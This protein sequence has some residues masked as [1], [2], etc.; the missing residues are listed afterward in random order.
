MTITTEETRNEYTATASQTVFNYTFKIFDDTDLSVYQT[1]SGA[2]A[3][4]VSDLITGYS[5]SGEGD[6]DGGAITLNTGATLGDLITIVSNIPKSRT[7]NYQNNGDFKPA[8]VNEDFDR[9]VSI[10]KQALDMASRALLLQESQQGTKP[11]SLPNPEAGSHLKW[12]ATLDGMENVVIG[13]GLELPVLQVSSYASVAAAIAAIG[14]TSVELWLDTNETLQAN[15]TFNANTTIRPIN[16][17]L[18]SDDSNNADLI[19]GGA[20]IAAPGQRLFNWG[21]G[22]GS[23]TIIKGPVWAG[24]FYDGLDIGKAVNQA[25]IANITVLIEVGS[26]PLLTTIVQVS[27]GQNL[28]GQGMDDATTIEKQADITGITWGMGEGSLRNFTLD[29]DGSDS[30]KV[31]ISYTNGARTYTDNVEVINQDSHGFDFKKGNLA[32]FG[33]IKAKSNGGNGFYCDGVDADTNAGKISF[34]EATGNTLD[35]LRL[36]GSWAQSWKIN[37]AVCQSNSRYGTYLD[38]IQCEITTY[39]EDNTTDDGV[40]GT[41]SQGV[42]AKCL[43]NGFTDNGTAK[44]NEVRQ[45]LNTKGTQG[46]IRSKIKELISTD[47]VTAG[48]WTQEVTGVGAFRIQLD[49]TSTDGTLTIDHASAPTYKTSLAVGGNMNVG[50]GK[51]IGAS[52]TSARLW[53]G[54]GSPEG[55]QAASPGSL[56]FNVSGTSAEYPQYQKLTGTG[57][58]GWTGLGTVYP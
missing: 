56:W 27:S 32:V 34:L 44:N 19:I 54:T 18:L 48:V 42:L 20:I 3:N 9:V 15:T 47:G 1:S 17:F 4:D 46:V 40:L 22:S 13:N 14:S 11:F 5:V 28:I 7:T 29:S 2:V 24:W 50:A 33:F 58:T 37:Y 57:N 53:F 55:V 39:N 16:G 6:E 12:N 21:N 31:G 43:L 49:G 51:Y 30:G 52:G 41:S 36:D 23:I 10:A 26:F 38:V 25:F 35:G 8:V 45:D